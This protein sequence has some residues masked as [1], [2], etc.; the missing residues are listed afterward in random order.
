LEGPSHPERSH[1][2][3]LDKRFQFQSTLCLKLLA[4]LD[5]FGKAR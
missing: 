1:I 3:L 5:K 4:V 2:R